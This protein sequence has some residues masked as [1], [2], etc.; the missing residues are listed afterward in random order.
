MYDFPA[1]V[2]ADSKLLF[3]KNDKHVFPRETRASRAFR[4]FDSERSEKR[5]VFTTTFFFVL[6][7]SVNTCSGRKFFGQKKG[8][9][10]GLRSRY[11]VGRALGFF[12]F[13]SNTAKKLG[14]ELYF[15]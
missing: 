2:R 9:F 14:S 6:C 3:S 10:S 13:T 12:F 4:F 11:L 1:A 5:I 7:F 8:K 15:V